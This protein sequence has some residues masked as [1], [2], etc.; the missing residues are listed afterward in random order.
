MTAPAVVEDPRLAAVPT[1]QTSPEDRSHLR[2]LLLTL[3]AV[4]LATAWIVAGAL[5][6]PQRRLLVTATVVVA[7]SG[8]G[9]L[10]YRA[11]GLY[12]ARVC[13]LRSVEHTRL[14]QASL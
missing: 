2:A 4:T 7:L 3:D 6:G 10:L 14:A 13:S 9:I 8:L 5:L 11:F 12:R 1:T